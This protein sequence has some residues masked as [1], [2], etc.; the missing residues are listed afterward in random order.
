VRPFSGCVPAGEAV[1]LYITVNKDAAAMF[2]DDTG[3]PEIEVRHLRPHAV[4]LNSRV[5]QC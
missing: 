4:P 5:L 2:G 3:Q 1:E